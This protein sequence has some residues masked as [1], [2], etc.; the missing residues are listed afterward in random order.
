MLKKGQC[1]HFKRVSVV[2]K[3]ISKPRKESFACFLRS[4]FKNSKM[5]CLFFK[6]QKYYVFVNVIKKHF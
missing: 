4:T 2:A 1:S 3:S 5:V 6:M